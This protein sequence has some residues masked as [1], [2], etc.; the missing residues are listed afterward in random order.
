MKI[1]VCSCGSPSLPVFE[2]S[3]RAYAPEHELI[4]HHVERSTFGQCYNAAMEEAFKDSEEIIISND[5]VVITPWTIP[6]LLEDVRAIKE[7]GFEKIGFVATYAD[8]AK[9]HQNIQ[10][11]P[12]ENR[13]NQ[14]TQSAMVLPIFAWFNRQAFEEAQFPP[15]NWFS[16]DVIC[17]DLNRKGYSHF[18]SRTHVHHVGS[19]TTGR[20]EKK[21]T[22]DSLPW[23]KENRPEYVKMWFNNWSEL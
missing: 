23:L 14:I 5:D 10:Y 2:A 7:H 18:I 13:L 11:V 15:L 6:I 1:V 20:D 22:E 17:E 9:K 3:V 19:T 21:L 4:V 12:E 16:D 8:F